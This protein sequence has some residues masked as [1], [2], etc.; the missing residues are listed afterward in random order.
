MR[1]SIS[2]LV[3]VVM[4]VAAGLAVVTG[5]TAPDRADASPAML[6]G[7]SAIAF[8]QAVMASPA[9]VTGAEW[10]TRFDPLATATTSVAIGGF[11]TAGSTYG[12]MG[13]GDTSTFDR[14]INP[15]DPFDPFDPFPPGGPSSGP[16]QG[17]AIRG[18]TDRDVTI[19]RIDFTVPAGVNCLVGLDFRFYSAEY[20]DFVGQEYNDAFIAE[21]DQSTWT[22][23]GSTISAPDNFA[24]DPNNN[25]ITVNAAGASSMYAEEAAG[26]GYGGATA[27]LRAR[28]PI[29]PG[30][31]SLFLSI[32]DQ[33]DHSLDSVVAIDSV[34][35]G[36]V[37]DP[38]VDCR[39]GATPRFADPK[40]VALGDG[41]ASG[42]GLVPSFDPRNGCGRSPLAYPSF[43]QPPDQPGVTVRSLAA[44][45]G[46]TEW[47]FQACAGASTTQ[48]VARGRWRDALA[49]LATDRTRD[50][51]N[52][53]DLPVDWG[54][55]LVTLSIG[56]EDARYLAIL[57]ICVNNDDC[58]I[59]RFRG[60]LIPSDWALSLR[61]LSVDLAAAL[62]RIRQQAPAAEVLV[63]GYPMPFPSDPAAQDCDALEQISRR[64]GRMT[65]TVGFTNEEQDMIRSLVG[66]LNDTIAAA[67]VAS[68]VG[69]FVDTA[70]L[71]TTHE[72]CGSGGA[73]IG[74]PALERSRATRRYELPDS[75]FMP[76][77]CGQRALAALVNEEIND[78][79]PSV[80]C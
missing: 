15:D 21:L 78:I 66:D 26:T 43:V 42:Q 63:L 74:G 38:A 40:Y 1:R 25:P 54:T 23:S 11:P 41:F 58:T 13:T 79:S 62:V 52:D 6:T 39:Q 36:S 30:A 20:P 47:G 16:V 64:N 29:T 3:V 9:T 76:T 19:L 60:R 32:F 12:V 70:T 50:R 68:G 53:H 17:E 57:D 8:A 73:W 75:A 34:E 65:R 14:V 51:F 67:V 69:T 61:R 46:G 4:L 56:A 37:L 72:I 2:G 7:G 31:H 71:F 28:T 5:T 77:A 24:F 44:R 80:G 48:L 27:L 18:D 55:D 33:G 10:V 22:T 49:Q 45:G 59:A 35:F